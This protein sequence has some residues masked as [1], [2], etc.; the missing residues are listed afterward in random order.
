MNPRS[1]E[2]HDLIK[3]RRS[4]VFYMIL[5]QLTDECKVLCPTV[6]TF[7]IFSSLVVFLTLYVKNL[8]REKFRLNTW[9]HDRSVNFTNEIFRETFQPCCR[10]YEDCLLRKSPISFI[11]VLPLVSYVWKTFSLI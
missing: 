10:L 11:S 3:T 6:C 8:T 5:L 7:I 1:D 9:F 2:T 4:E